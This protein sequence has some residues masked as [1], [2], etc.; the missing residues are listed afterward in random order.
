[1]TRFSATLCA[2][3]C[4][5]APLSAEAGPE[6]VAVF[7][8][9][10]RMSGIP[11]A[12]NDDG[13]AWTAEQLLHQPS[14]IKLDRLL[15]IRMKGQDEGS[16][17][18]D[19]QALLSLRNGDSISGEFI[20]LDDKFVTLRTWYG[21]DLRINRAMATDM[22]IM[23]AER[24]IYTGPT[25]I[26][27]WT[28]I[29][30]KDAWSVTGN[31][32]VSSQRG[33]VAKEIELPNKCHFGFDLAWRSGLNF[34][35][36]LFADEG[37]TTSPDNY[38]DLVCQRRFVYL[39]KRWSANG[40]GGTLTIGRPA[41]I[42]ELADQEDVRLD[43]Y[44]DREAGTI[45]LYV[46]DRQ[47]E[48]WTDEDAAAGAFGDWFHFVA[49]EY[50]LRISNIRASAWKGDLPEGTTPEAGEDAIDEEGQVILLQNG[51]TVI[52]E[53]GE[54]KDGILTITSK[55][56]EIPV[57]VRRMR[58]IDLTGSDYDEPI[59]K[60]GDIRAWLKGGGRITFRLDSFRDGKMEG[61]SQSFGEATFDLSAFSRLEF[62]IYDENLDHL[63]DGGDW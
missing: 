14:T 40:R 53:V 43:F 33:S 1:M 22:E 20:D 8:N 61:Y 62:N 47:A 21:G 52:G 45:A 18:S 19:H 34:H 23:R 32:L 58:R 37:D 35:L 24:A 16:H 49:E 28:L 10:D 12:M 48:V 3:A 31:Q 30:N 41:N 11:G 56:G 26:K 2:F 39:R 27:N 42:R 59:R 55:H 17:P 44:V 29:G 50:P 60:N 6:G 54:V 9:G 46:D 15:E 51:D 63:R 38:Y 7:T 57:P 25:D 5:V 13:L 36:Y 4:L